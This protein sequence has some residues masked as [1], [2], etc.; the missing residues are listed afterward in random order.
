MILKQDKLHLVATEGRDP[1]VAG[2]MSAY[3]DI[4]NLSE[5]H[6]Y[7]PEMPTALYFKIQIA[8]ETIG[9]INLKNIRWFNRKAEF[10]VFIKKDFRGRG[11]G[12]QAVEM[13]MEY[14]FLTMNLHRL[15]AEVVAYNTAMQAMLEKLGFRPEGELREA[16]YFKGKY[17]SIFRYGLLRKEY[18]QRHNNG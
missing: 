2:L 1:E 14:V 18:L 10:S 13:I 17:H 8:R 6:M 16:K 4:Q 3:E 5:V 9:E 11:L 12:R 15:E 7:P